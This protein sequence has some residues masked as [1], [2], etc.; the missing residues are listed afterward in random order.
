MRPQGQPLSGPPLPYGQAAVSQ[1][2]LPNFPGR[3]WVASG[4][5]GAGQ[6]GGLPP[7]VE[8]GFTIEAAPGCAGQPSRLAVRLRDP[9]R[10]G[11]AQAQWNLGNSAVPLV[12][13]GPTVAPIFGQAGQQPVYVVVTLAMGRGR[14]SAWC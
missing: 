9:A 11:I 12:L 10:R 1:Y 3:S 5:A 13:T 8:E 14:R 7:A 2:C 6:P 4:S